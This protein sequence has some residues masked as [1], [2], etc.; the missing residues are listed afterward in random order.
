MKAGDRCAD[1]DHMQ[2]LLV[3]ALFGESRAPG[4]P[5]MSS[6]WSARRSSCPRWRPRANGSTSN[7]L[8]LE[9]ARAYAAYGQNSFVGKILE[10]HQE[11][12]GRIHVVLVRQAIGF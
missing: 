10:I 11:M 6:S 2:R 4:V 9:D 12:P 7:S 1:V 8:Q 5:P 3:G